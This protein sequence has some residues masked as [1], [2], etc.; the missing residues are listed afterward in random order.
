MF[1]FIHTVI[2]MN[3]QMYAS[4]MLSFIGM[5]PVGVGMEPEYMAKYSKLK[6]QPKKL[7]LKNTSYFAN[8]NK[9]KTLKDAV[10]LANSMV[11]STIEEKFRKEHDLDDNK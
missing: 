4:T 10:S 5:A 6:E 11:N 8:F 3:H 1:E 7:T 9:T 2:D